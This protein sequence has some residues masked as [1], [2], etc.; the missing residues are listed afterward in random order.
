[1]KTYRQGTMSKHVGQLKEGD[2]ILVKGPILK[3]PYTA[4]MKRKVGM[5]AGAHGH[6]ATH[7][8]SHSYTASIPPLCILALAAPLRETLLRGFLK[9]RQARYWCDFAM[10]QY[11][12]P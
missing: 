5:I 2:S 3:L 1:M 4:N 11:G 8:H 10:Q 12:Q 9:W 7:T 6:P